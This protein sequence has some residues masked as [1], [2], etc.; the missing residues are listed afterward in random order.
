MKRQSFEE[1]IIEIMIC[2]ILTGILWLP[3][4]TSNMYL[5]N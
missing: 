5:L 3:T 1:A 4:L 2:I